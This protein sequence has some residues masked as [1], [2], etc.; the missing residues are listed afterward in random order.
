MKGKK[1]T[2][3]LMAVLMVVTMLPVQ[4]LAKDDIAL[5]DEEIAGAE[6]II[7]TEDAVSEEPLD[8]NTIAADYIC[9]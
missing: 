8:E 9:C 6:T 2:A 3:I 4:A 5:D 1:I 7:L